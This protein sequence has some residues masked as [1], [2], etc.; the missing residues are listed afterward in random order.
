MPAAR[1]TFFSHP[2]LKLKKGTPMF[3]RKQKFPLAKV[4]AAFAFG[5]LSGAVL[6][7]LYAPMTGKKM[8]K[9]IASVTDNVLEKVEDG[10]ETV[11]ATVRSI[12]RA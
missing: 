12:S 5:A 2:S 10:V 6:A 3:N 9:K 7:L 11:Q 4:G 1:E 8:Q